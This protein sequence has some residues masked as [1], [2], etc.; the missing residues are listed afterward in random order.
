[1][2]HVFLVEV[3][4]LGIVHGHKGAH[5]QCLSSMEYELYVVSDEQRGIGVLP[6][7]RELLVHA[8]RTTCTSL[9]ASELPH[10]CQ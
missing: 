7:T 2:A 4:R 10:P 9:L 5:I 3:A 6:R 1:M 8:W